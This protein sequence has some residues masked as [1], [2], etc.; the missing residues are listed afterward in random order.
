MTLHPKKLCFYANEK[1]N[2]YFA[3]SKKGSKMFFLILQLKKGLDKSGPENKQ[4][5]ARR[6]SR[7]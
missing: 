6:D 4:Q 7:K 5:K 1:K 2:Y 3:F